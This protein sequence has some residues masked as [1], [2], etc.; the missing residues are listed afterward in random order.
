VD[1]QTCRLDPTSTD[2]SAL[3]GDELATSF[4]ATPACPAEELD[5]GDPVI[6]FGDTII[7]RGNRLSLGASWSDSDFVVLDDLSITPNGQ[8]SGGVASRINIRCDDTDDMFLDTT[9][10]TVSDLQD[11]D[12]VLEQFREQTTA[13]GPGT[14]F[15]PP[16]AAP[17]LDESFLTNIL[18]PP[19]YF[20]KH[21]RYRA[22]V[23]TVTLGTSPINLA[24]PVGLNAVV[25]NTTF[26]DARAQFTILGGDAAAPSTQLVLCLDSP[27]SSVAVTGTLAGQENPGS[28]G[29]YAAWTSYVSAAGIRDEQMQTVGYV[30]FCKSI[31]GAVT[32][33]DNDCLADSDPRDDVGATDKDQDDDGLL[34]GI[35]AT[36]LGSAAC[37]NGGGDPVDT[38]DCDGDGNLDSEEMLQPTTA[39]TNP[40]SADSDGDGFI[41][42][43]VRLDCDG[44]GGP[45]SPDVGGT[46]T[47]A[48]PAG[49]NR[50][51]FNVMYCKPNGTST[52]A[53]GLGGRPVGNP[54][55]PASGLAESACSDVLDN[56]TDGLV[57]DGCASN[58]EDNCPAIGNG[59]QVNSSTVDPESNSNP[60]DGTNGRFGPSVAVPGQGDVL[61]VD[62]KFSGDACDGDDDNDGVADS[63]EGAMF[64]DPSGATEGSG[65]NFC[66]TLDD[67][68]PGSGGTQT[69]EVAAVTSGTTRDTDGD[70]TIDGVECQLATN[71][72]DDTSKPGLSFT[73]EQS[74]YYRL[75]NLAQV[76]T[77]VLVTLDDGSTVG[78]V[79]EAKGYGAG[80]A[81][82]NDT[83]RDGCPDETEAVDTN[84]D[85]IVNDADRL[86]IAR[87]VLGAGT[88]GPPG[89]SQADLEER[90]T[91]DVVPN[92]ILDD[93]DRLGA[94]RIALSAS[95]STV[96]DY[97]LNCT[98]AVLGYAGN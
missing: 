85:R 58:P 77:T 36:Y 33:A 94:A 38:A 49:R 2:E 63:V 34:D 50:V 67:D 23:D 47:T 78:G 7:H 3:T 68:G 12:L 21:V 37:P 15:D 80:A 92:G 72:A 1:N 35:D 60:A 51:M 61:H 87:A 96:P 28:P 8:V 90:R 45:D 79:P 55:P 9:S 75:T 76:G 98:A 81:S 48:N 13:W 91:A 84:G 73:T 27:Q 54:P 14:G 5:A 29:L 95:L 57:N 25:L 18:P 40:R 66:N 43:G 39:L 11:G 52:N 20:P 22:D 42:S 89:S 82:S 71:P 64:Y 16:G 6:T 74:I 26:G 83:D 59:T 97:N 53:S 10:G 19:S 56:D 24:V 62:A 93:P 69:N 46:D 88:F 44:I 30:T 65:Q 17:P 32:D 86:G 4:P 41:D 70:G 31:G